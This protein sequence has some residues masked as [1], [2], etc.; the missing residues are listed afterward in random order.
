MI[1]AESDCSCPR[2]A[3][4]VSMPPQPYSMSSGWA[5]RA[6]TF[7]APR[8]GA[9]PPFRRSSHAVGVLLAASPQDRIAR[10]K[11]AL[12][13]RRLLLVFGLLF[14]ACRWWLW[15]PVVARPEDV[16]GLIAVGQ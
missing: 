16:E 9:S 6:R 5:P 10:A 11:P 3:Y 7:I 8:R 15:G 4:L 2:T 14:A 1:S 12:E 13:R